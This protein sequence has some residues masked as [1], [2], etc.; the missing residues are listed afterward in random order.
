MGLGPVDT[1]LVLPCQDPEG[2]KFE[3]YH[4]Y[5]DHAKKKFR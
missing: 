5:L 4:E 1:R 3:S 2:N